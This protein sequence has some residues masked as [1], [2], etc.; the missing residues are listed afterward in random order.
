M[1]LRPARP[2]SA[3]A[4]EPDGAALLAEARR[5]LSEELLSQLPEA[6]RYEARMIANAMAIAGRELG[7][8][9]PLADRSRELATAIRA[10]QH[11]SDTD[12]RDR[13]AADVLARLAISN[14]KALPRR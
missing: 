3:P 8:R 5:L 6:R 12:L 4:T 2:G 7:A 1:T 9:T 14:P 11:D 10:G 13:L